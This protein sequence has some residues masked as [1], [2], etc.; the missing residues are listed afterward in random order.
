MWLYAGIASVRLW[1]RYIEMEVKG[2]DWL[3]TR[4]I[5]C[6]RQKRKRDILSSQAEKTA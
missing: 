4:N 5:N 1:R 6:K 3:D 2:R